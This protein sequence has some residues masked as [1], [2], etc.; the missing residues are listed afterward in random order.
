[1]DIAGEDNG[2]VPVLAW[3][4]IPGVKAISTIHDVLMTMVTRRKKV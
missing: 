4:D 1:L 3:K 2:I